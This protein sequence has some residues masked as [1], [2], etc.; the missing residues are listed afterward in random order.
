MGFVVETQQIAVARRVCH[1]VTAA[2]C[3][4][5]GSMH[6]SKYIMCSCDKNQDEDKLCKQDF[7]YSHTLGAVLCVLPCSRLR[8][9]LTYL[10]PRQ[11]KL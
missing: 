9:Q 11:A 4:E 5:G 1:T 10:S 7:A 8:T 3:Q 6:I 2:G